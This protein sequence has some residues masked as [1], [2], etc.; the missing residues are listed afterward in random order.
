MQSILRIMGENKIVKAL[1]PCNPT[2]EKK[3][4]TFKMLIPV[5]TLGLDKWLSVAFRM[6]H[7]EK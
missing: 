2:N 3:G 7:E 1:F 6:S 4:R 5:L